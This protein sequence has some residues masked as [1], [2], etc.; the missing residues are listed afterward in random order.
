MYCRRA[1][2]LLLFGRCV[3]AQA[4]TGEIAGTVYDPAGGVVPN[5]SIA[6]KN[7]ATSFDRVLRSNRAGQYSVPSLASWKAVTPVAMV[8]LP[9][10]RL[11]LPLLSV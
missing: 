10:L 4:P 3:L 6:V 2:L 8:P 11:P 9:C 1:A 5:A 7:A